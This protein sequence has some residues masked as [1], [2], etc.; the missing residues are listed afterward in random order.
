M[1]NTHWNQPTPNKPANQQTPL[2]G[3]QS[4]YLIQICN[5]GNRKNMIYFE[6]ADKNQHEVIL[7][8]Y[9]FIHL[10][11]KTGSTTGGCTQ[12]IDFPPTLLDFA[13]HH[14]YDPHSSRT[15]WWHW[16]HLIILSSTFR[17]RLVDWF[18]MQSAHLCYILPP[19][20]DQPVYKCSS[21]GLFVSLNHEAINKQLRDLAGTLKK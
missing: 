13:D 8:N 11:I 1:I 16:P 7:V 15:S 9:C 2:S 4:Q 14:N 20:C 21:L 18:N 3:E 10:E 5:F 6:I 19:A 17:C 12:C